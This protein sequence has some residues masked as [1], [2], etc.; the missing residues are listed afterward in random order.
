MFLRTPNGSIYLAAG[1]KTVSLT[2]AEWAATSPQTFTSV[3]QSLVDKLLVP[4]TQVT[5]TDAQFADFKASTVPIVHDAAETGA[6]DG[7]DGA[8]IHPAT[9]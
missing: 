6:R 3:P 1:G 7:L 2:S 5:L 4:A 8:T 9:P